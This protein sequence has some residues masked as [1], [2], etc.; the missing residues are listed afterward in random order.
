MLVAEHAPNPE[1]F[2]PHD[3]ALEPPW[4]HEPLVVVSGREL[5]P[6]DYHAPIVD[7][8]MDDGRPAYLHDHAFGVRDMGA[9]SEDH[10]MGYRIFA[11]YEDG[12][13]AHLSYREPWGVELSNDVDLNT[14]VR[15][16]WYH[17]LAAPHTDAESFGE[18]YP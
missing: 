17:G 18:Y 10:L 6:G 15:V 11:R 3:H 8:R 5:V 14:G 1:V 9:W 4:R 2:D 16:P 13:L 12:T 7:P